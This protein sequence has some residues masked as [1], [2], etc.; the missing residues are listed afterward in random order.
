MSTATIRD[1]A[2]QAKVS[3][4]TVS[5]VIN[6]VATVKPHT[7]EKVLRVIRKLDYHPN[8]SARG[9]SGSRSYLIGL[10]YDRSCEY[11]AATV[12]AGVVETCRAAHYQVVMQPC[13]YRS[14]GLADEVAR[15]VKHSRAD[16]VILTPPLSDLAALVDVLKEKD[17]PFVRIA[18]AEHP[19]TFR[20]VYTNDR[21]SSARMIEHL[22]ALGHTRIG[23]IIGNPDHAAVGD[24]HR[25]YLDG[26]KN[27]G[28][29]FD[30]TLVA[31]GYNSHQSG[32]QCAR[33]LLQLP[34][35]KRPTAI[36]ASNDEMAAGVLAVAHGFGIGV[37]DDISVAGFDD[38]PLASQVWPALTTIRQP[39]GPM[40][41]KAADLLL[42]QLR[43]EADEDEAHV[44]ESSL[45]FRQSTGPAH[46]QK[47]EQI[48][49]ARRA[50]AALAV[51][52]AED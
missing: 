4:K 19:D 31:Q 10:L 3:I 52:P 41:A 11:Y 47:L 9:L 12:L 5:R 7:R 23:F 14:P 32:M 34:E 44:L 35:G 50:R 15:N 1:V 42:R 26:L 37:P 24:R 49:S 27:C 39:I 36:F 48:R 38:S 45:T 16:G 46:N 17:I 29:E 30:K 18:P 43:G 21:E 40:S 33:K 20:S 6:N 51:A 28:L 8:A 25:G 22:A 2:A 13:D